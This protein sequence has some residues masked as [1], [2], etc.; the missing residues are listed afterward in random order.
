MSDILSGV[1][2]QAVVPVC[3]NVSERHGDTS[4]QVAVYEQSVRIAEKNVLRQTSSGQYYQVAKSERQRRWKE[5][6]L[7]WLL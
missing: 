5:I 2:T 6:T 3:S 1:D 4:G 7:L